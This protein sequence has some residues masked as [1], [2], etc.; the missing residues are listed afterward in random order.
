MSRLPTL[1]LDLDRTLVDVQ[2]FTA[3]EVVCQELDEVFGKIRLSEMPE[4]GWRS[5]THRAMAIL[6]SLAGVE[7]DWA[8]ADEIV[9][10]H[11]LAA[12]DEATAMPHLAEFLEDT[13]SAER[14]IV[15]LMGQ[16]PAEETCRRFGI[17]IPVIVGR[18]ADLVPKPAPDQ[19]LAAL[20]L[21]DSSA[22]DALMVGDSPWDANAAVAAGTA[23]IGVTNG[24]PSVFTAET[25]VVD[26]LQATLGRLG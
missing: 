24:K 8:H 17:E 19:L 2:T 20:D 21:L 26:D 1:L 3:Y 22:R 13:A 9:S 23:F 18:R 14:A 11:E 5:A 6:F 7:A 4:S 12:I 10:R 25:P 16:E 15:T